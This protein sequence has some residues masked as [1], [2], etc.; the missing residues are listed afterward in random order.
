M[1]YMK[2][3]IF[4][5]LV[6]NL[7]HQLLFIHKIIFSSTCVETQVLIFRRIQLYT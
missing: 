4:Y 2:R 7:M 5:I 6:T 1:K 3:K